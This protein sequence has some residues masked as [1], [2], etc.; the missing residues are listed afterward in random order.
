MPYFERL[1]MSEKEKSLDIG[2]IFAE[3]EGRGQRRAVLDEQ[4]QLPHTKLWKRKTPVQK[5]R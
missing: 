2:T 3:E 4:N 5:R 1:N